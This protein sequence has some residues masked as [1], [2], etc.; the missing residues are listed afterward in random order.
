[1]P[2]RG[3]RARIVVEVR[4]APGRAAGAHRAR[5]P[6][7]PHPSFETEV[8]ARERPHR[9]YVLGH[10]RVVVVQL[11]PGRNDDLGE[12]AALA[13]VQDRISR[14]LGGKSHAPRAHDASFGVVDDGRAEH[15]ALRLV[16][17]LVVHAFL[18]AV[19]LEPIVLEAALAGLIADRAIDGVVQKKKLLNLGASLRHLVGRLALHF[20]VLDHRHLA[21]RLELRLLRHDVVVLLFVPGEDVEH[22]RALTGRRRDLD[23]AHAA[24]GGNAEPRVPA[25]MRN[26]DPHPVSGADD[27]VP[28]FEGNVASVELERGHGLPGFEKRRR[29]R[30]VAKAGGI[31]FSDHTRL[32]SC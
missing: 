2:V 18:L 27:R 19:V 12:V 17:R 11:S 5:G 30:E 26:V 13:L 28:F 24:V 7:K 20:H 10:E 9:A 29:G 6:E 16:D 4:A 8:G 23:Q 3:H 1:M 21:S 14:D 22:H 15:D 32:R 31:R 25:V